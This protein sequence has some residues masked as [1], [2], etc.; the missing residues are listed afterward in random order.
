[1]H[2]VLCFDLTWFNSQ[3]KCQI[4]CQIYIVYMVTDCLM[5]RLDREPI[6]FVKL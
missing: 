1:M 6:L 3:R 5:D 4:Y 2:R